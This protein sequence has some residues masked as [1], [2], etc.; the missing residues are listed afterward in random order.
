M[1]GMEG[2]KGCW[3]VTW[4]AHIS[5]R[6]AQSTNEKHKQAKPSIQVHGTEHLQPGSSRV[7][8]L[9]SVAKMLP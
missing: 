5:T 4:R 1:G 2:D 8:P 7:R 6:S 3:T 9:A